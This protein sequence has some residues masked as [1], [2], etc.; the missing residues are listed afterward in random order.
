MYLSKYKHLLITL[1]LIGLGSAL[2]SYEYIVFFS[3]VKEENES[4]TATSSSR[5]VITP[6]TELIIREIYSLCQKY[7]LE[8]GTKKRIEGSVRTRFNNL[9]EKELKKEYPE[10]GGWNIS[11]QKSQVVLEQVREGLCPEHSSRWHLSYNDAKEKIAVYLGPSALG[12]ESETI[13]V[14]DIN[15]DSLPADLRNKITEGLMEFFDWEELI[16]TLDSLTEYNSQ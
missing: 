4:T 13:M 12:R 7:G 15:L 2:A 9:T 16:A 1:V 6:K 8:C 3:Q 11:W 14:T 10:A 5:L